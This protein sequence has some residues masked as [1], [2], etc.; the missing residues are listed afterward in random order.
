LVEQSWIERF[1]DEYIEG[2]MLKDLRY[3]ANVKD[4]NLS[5]VVANSVFDAMDFLSRC[6]APRSPH[7]FEDFLGAFFKPGY[8]DKELWKN[9]RCGLNHEYFPRRANAVTWNRPEIHLKLENGR[10]CLNAQDLVSDLEEAVTRYREA[11]RNDE[12]LRVNFEIRAKELGFNLEKLHTG[13]IWVGEQS[14]SS[15][16]SA[17]VVLLRN[18][19]GTTNE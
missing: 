16:S 12:T 9:Y 3:C 18:F 4:E 6:W 8:K 11:L 14:Y 2:W 15:S 7:R 10:L 17:P 5:F 19:A 13:V 1:F